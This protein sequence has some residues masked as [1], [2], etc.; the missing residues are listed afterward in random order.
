[1]DSDKWTPSVPPLGHEKMRCL[2]GASIPVLRS[3]LSAQEASLQFSGTPALAWVCHYWDCLGPHFPLYSHDKSLPF[4]NQG[5]SFT[6]V[7]G[8]EAEPSDTA[9]VTQVNSEPQIHPGMLLQPTLLLH[10]ASPFPSAVQKHGGLQNMLTPRTSSLQ[11]PDPSLLL[12]VLPGMCLGSTG[13]PEGPHVWTQWKRIGKHLETPILWQ[14]RGT[15][16]NFLT[17]QLRNKKKKNSMP[18]VLFL[19]G[20]VSQSCSRKLKE[21][22]A[23]TAHSKINN[24]WEPDWATSSC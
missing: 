4:G 16:H 6:D 22:M 15:A 12:S 5:L 13:H 10:S 7:S 19:M 14:L 3:V 20:I 11:S 18:S 9:Q 8:E 17:N 1:M 24:R 23:L 21:A 2:P